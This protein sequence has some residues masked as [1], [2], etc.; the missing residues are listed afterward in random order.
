MTNNERSHRLN[1]DRYDQNLFRDIYS[2]F[3]EISHN[4]K[5]KSD[6]R[7]ECRLRDVFLQRSFDVENLSEFF[8]TNNQMNR[9]HVTFQLSSSTS[10][11]KEEQSDHSRELRISSD[12]EVT[13]LDY[14]IED[15]EET[16]FTL[17]CLSHRLRLTK[18]KKLKTLK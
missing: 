2:T 5:S 17:E 16:I 10:R 1:N 11:E 4:L 13:T 15:H 8:K 7:S 6:N 14:Y 18:E 12:Y 3:L 9:R